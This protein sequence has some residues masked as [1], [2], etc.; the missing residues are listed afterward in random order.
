MCGCRCC[1]PFPFVA[2]SGKHGAGADADERGHAGDSCG[3]DLGHVNRQE[4]LADGKDIGRMT[5]RWVDAL[6]D[7]WDHELIY[8]RQDEGTAGDGGRGIG[9]RGIRLERMIP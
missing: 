2:A 5:R 1:I 7:G 9:H 4:L 3:G 8:R 6:I